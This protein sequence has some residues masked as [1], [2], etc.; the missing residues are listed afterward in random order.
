MYTQEFRVRRTRKDGTL[1][2]RYFKLLYTAALRLGVIL[3]SADESIE[4]QLEGAPSKNI[5]PHKENREAWT[6]TLTAQDVQ[7][8]GKLVEISGVTAIVERNYN[9]TYYL[10]TFWP[11]SQSP[12]ARDS[13]TDPL[14]DIAMSGDAPESFLE[15]VARVMHKEFIQNPGMSPAVAM[16]DLNSELLESIQQSADREIERWKATTQRALDAQKEALS[17]ADAYKVEALKYKEES[18]RFQSMLVEAVAK[19]RAEP[20]EDTTVAFTDRIAASS[21]TSKWKSLTGSAYINVGIN[22]Y[23][24]S[25][26]QVRNKIE[27]TYI[28]E[29]GDER[30]IFDFGYKGFVAD[31][32]EYLRGRQNKSAVFIVTRKPEGALMLASDTMMLP[33]YRA[34]W[35]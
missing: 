35:R 29:N 12:D 25:V 10:I 2:H 19:Q 21:V 27:L 15:Y 1:N 26:T 22:A 20:A 28:D 4:F 34:L 32:Y 14:V 17:I 8:G 9:G 33:K 31:V 30:R 7:D 11:E 24:I 5:Q 23:V 3:K 6:G 16:Q 18:E 13:Y